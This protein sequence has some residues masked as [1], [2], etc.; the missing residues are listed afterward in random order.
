MGQKTKETLFQ[1]S[2]VERDRFINTLAIYGLDEI[3]N[4]IGN[5]HIARSN[6][7]KFDIGGRVYGSLIGFLEK[8]VRQF[9]E[10]K[11]AKSNF[12][13]QKNDG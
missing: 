13:R 6:P 1:V 11:T 5:Y 9:Y 12:R 3:F 8:G 2:S 4:A 10:D 7:E